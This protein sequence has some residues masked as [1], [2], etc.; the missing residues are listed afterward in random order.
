M[1]DDPKSPAFFG[2]RG[3]RRSFVASEGMTSLVDDEEIELADAHAELGVGAEAGRFRDDFTCCIAL[4][5]SFTPGTLYIFEKSLVFKS[6][7][8]VESHFL[9]LELSL[10]VGVRFVDER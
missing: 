7:R 6:S 4:T 2:T 8:L 5:D 3:R 10:I 1:D 9:L